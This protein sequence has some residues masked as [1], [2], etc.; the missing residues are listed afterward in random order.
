MDGQNRLKELQSSRGTAPWGRDTSRWVRPSVWSSRP[1]AG[2][3]GGGGIWAEPS[4]L[5]CRN[6]LPG[7]QEAQVHRKPDTRKEVRHSLV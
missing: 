6:R 5:T 7:P 1:G 4:T 3:G 2:M